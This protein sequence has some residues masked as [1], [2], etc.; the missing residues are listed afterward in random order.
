MVQWPTMRATALAL[1]TWAAGCS[2]VIVGQFGGSGSS[3]G[4][5]AVDDASS[6]AEGTVTDGQTG[7]GLPFTCLSDD[8][9]DGIIDDGLWFTWV[10]EDAAIEEVDGRLALTPP[11]YGV[12]DT[13][14]AGG[15]MSAFPFTDGT[16]RVSIVTPPP[17][18]RPAGLFVQ[19]GQGTDVL[20]LSL[21]SGEIGVRRTVDD[22]TMFSEEF[23]V[24]VDPSGL[25]FAA[26][27]STIDFEISEDGAT[28]TS[29]YSHTLDEPLVEATAL[30][31][32]QSYGDNPGPATLRVDDFEACFR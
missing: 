29:V 15:S 18:D 28:W 20:L 9:E 21:G 10:E 13:G 3:V 25:G 2:D 19:V 22:V 11:S 23:P 27:G 5:T 7:S 14:V 17:R 30:I 1:I 4:S 24:A 16:V 8:F 12:F 26:Q 31:M 32:A 6:T